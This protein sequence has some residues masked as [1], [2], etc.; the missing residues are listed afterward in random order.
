MKSSANPLPQAPAPQMPFLTGWG[1]MLL[2]WLVPGLGFWL[3]HRR[4]RAV[5]QFL[6]VVVTFGFGIALHGGVDWPSWSM[7][8]PDFNLINNFTFLIQL[9]AGL[10]AL[11]SLFASQIQNGLGVPAFIRFV[12]E[13]LHLG[14]LGGTPTHP[15]YELGG[16][17]MIV[18]GAVNYFATCNLHDR[19]I[20]VHPNFAV[21]EGL[22]AEASTEEPS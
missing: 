9:F 10:P 21:Q 8:A 4:A 12:F 15:Y 6:L 20:R 16:Y 2:N 17:F 19:L 13:H 7:E 22:E 5:I 11:L 18:A 14:F 1:V 3:C